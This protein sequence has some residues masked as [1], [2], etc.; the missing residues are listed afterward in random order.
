MASLALGVV[1]GALLGPVGAAVGSAIGSYIDNAYIMPALFPPDDI[2]GPRLDDLAL[3]AASEGSPLN[4]AMG[5][6][7]RVGATVLWTSDLIEVKEKKKE[8]GKGGGGG[9]T[10]TTYKYFV[11]FAAEYNYVRTMS[12]VKKML[13]DGKLLYDAEPDL[14][15]TSDDISATYEHVIHWTYDPDRFPAWQWEIVKTYGYYWSPNGGPDLP[16][17]RSGRNVTV[18]GFTGTNTVLNGTFWCCASGAGA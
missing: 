3:T 14:S 4:F 13:A 10:V 1:G 15:I 16:Q 6:E 7:C 12:K 17:F 8:G 18:D 11:H 5:P 2:E 9:Q